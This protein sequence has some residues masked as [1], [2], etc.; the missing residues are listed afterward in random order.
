MATSTISR[1]RKS[2]SEARKE[3]ARYNRN[4]GVELKARRE[5]VGLSLKDVAGHLQVSVGLLC[6]MESGRRPWT[7]ERIEACRAYIQTNCNK[8][9]SCQNQTNKKK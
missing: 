6:D 2:I 8:V 3:L 4:I 5:C 7:D 9:K 1:I